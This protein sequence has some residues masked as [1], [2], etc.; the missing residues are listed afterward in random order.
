MEE[1]EQLKRIMMTQGFHLQAAQGE[2]A[3]LRG[4]QARTFEGIAMLSDIKASDLTTLQDIEARL[5]QVEGTQ[6]D[7][8]A[9]IQDIRT[10][11]TEQGL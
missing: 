8:K 6:G 4:M 1:L 7:I 11:L 5:T 3:E 10:K 2:L 9:L